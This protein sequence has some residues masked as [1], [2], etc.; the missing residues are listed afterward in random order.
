MKLKKIILPSHLYYVQIIDAFFKNVMLA[1]SA[2][3]PGCKEKCV[4]NFDL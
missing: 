4:G 3:L 1:I 2:H